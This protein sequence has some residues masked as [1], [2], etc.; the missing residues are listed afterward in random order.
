M[1]H[2]SR[3]LFEGL[4][5][6][7]TPRSRRASGRLRPDQLATQRLVLIQFEWA[8]A[9]GVQPVLYLQRTLLD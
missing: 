1:S 8:V 7:P 6:L 5:P 3:S 2:P 4:A 9:T